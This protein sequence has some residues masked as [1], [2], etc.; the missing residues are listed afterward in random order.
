MP[1]DL[2]LEQNKLLP[3]LVVMGFELEEI[4]IDLERLL[5][6]PLADVNLRKG[7]GGDRL[8]RKSVV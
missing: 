5:R 8:D 1:I 2:L 6:Q 7:R 4:A 3:Q